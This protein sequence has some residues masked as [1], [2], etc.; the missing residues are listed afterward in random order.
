M[1][2]FTS[3]RKLSRIKK[4]AITAAVLIL[5]YAI[6]GFFVLPPILKPLLISNIA[7]QLGREAAVKKIKVNPFA[8]SVT[9]QDFGLSEPDGERFVAFEELYVNFELSSIFRRAFTFAK[10]RLL[11]P[12]GRV[13]VLSDGTLNFSDILARLNPPDSETDPSSQGL[14]LPKLFIHNLKV[15]QG[16]L[17]LSD[18]SHPTPFET[19]IFP[20]HFTLNNLST[21]KDKESPYAFTAN[22]SKGGVVE[23]QGNFSVN[24]LRSQGRFEITGIKLRLL[25]EYI[26]DLV[27]FEIRDGAV[28]LAGQ[29]NVQ[30]YGDTIR[31]ELKD[32]GVQLAAFKLTEKGSDE[33]LVLVPSLSIQGVDFDLNEKRAVVASVHS[34]NAWL[35]AWRTRGGE[36][37]YQELIPAELPDAKSKETDEPT[38]GE[39]QAWEIRINEVVLENYGARLE[40]R[41]FEKP[42][43][44][45]LDSINLTLKNVSNQ[46]KSDAEI[47]LALLLDKKGRVKI[48]GVASMDPVS[49]DL[50]VGISKA[51]LRMAQAFLEGLTQVELASGTQNLDAQL[52]YNRFGDDGPLFRLEGDISFDDIK[53]VERSSSEDLLK[54]ASLAVNGLVFDSNPNKLSISEIVVKQPYAKV[55]IFPDATVNV[56]NAIATKDDETSKEI[57]RI[58]EKLLS[59]LEL[60]LEQQMPIAID[61]ARIE[62]GAA[63]FADL[64]VKPNF[65]A[66][67]RE[68]NGTIKGLSSKPK[69][70]A[71]VS[72]EGKVD[73]QAP[74]KITGRVNPLT[75]EIYANLALSFKR[76]NLTRVSPYSGKFAGY[77]IDKGRMS[78]DLK[79]EVSE[80]KLVGENEIFINQLTLG[81]RVDSP[82]A[83]S[84][85]V[86]LAVALLKDRNGNI[87][88]DVPV[89]GDPKDPEFNIGSV[90][91]KAFGNV[92]TKIVTSPFAAIAGLVGGGDGEDLSFVEFEFGSTTLGSKQID[93]LEKLAEALQER[94]ELKLEIEGVADKENDRTALTD[95]E[96]LRQLKLA[97]IKELRN[98]RKAVPARVE[99]VRLSY[100]DYARLITEKYVD[101]FGKDPK[102]IFL[103][104]SKSAAEKQQ[105]IDQEVII[106]AARQALLE[107]MAVDNSQLLRLAQERAMNIR[108]HLTQQ[109]RI[110]EDR[111]YMRGVE[112]IEGTAGDDI[113]T[114][115]TLSGV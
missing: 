59:F 101:R 15:E 67:I 63:D 56:V 84:L 85:P 28:D 66:D 12:D 1:G 2:T 102:T 105:A 107:T 109:G 100:D 61:K 18:L 83:T 10:I 39:Q 42:M 11:A 34:S 53:V 106:A 19:T 110:Q 17:A 82:D 115:L 16:R 99:D 75:P 70:R 29:Y 50:N 87:E 27:K 52:Q 38:D 40:N 74:V 36:I 76:M 6:N 41:A 37:N 112:I 23:W 103:G 35:A 92:I 7:E 114:N 54:C 46:K 111:L 24:P 64:F 14:E 47:N 77:L 48:Q 98:A 90:L 108:Q 78:V 45:T 94:P 73:N 51:P 113:R 91:G 21:L 97:K 96:L 89:R 69:T 95:A 30:I 68:L 49:A 58:F 8:F 86:S 5:L 93:K 79:Y 4:A 20:I 32:G 43:V 62:D 65:A 57:L 72:V 3:F 81:E 60:Q 25:W 31:A 71:H 9:V 55:I 80:D 104:E 22:L 33:E 26:Q 13:K 44:V 88:L